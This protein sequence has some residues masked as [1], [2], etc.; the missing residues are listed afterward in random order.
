MAS[1]DYLL[2]FYDMSVK[3]VFYMKSYMETLLMETR[4]C[5][6]FSD[7]EIQDLLMTMG[8]IYRIDYA[9]TLANIFELVLNAALFSVIFAERPMKLEMTRGKYRAIE[10]D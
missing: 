4:F 7:K 2:L 3:G 5:R 10:A 9:K 8:R 1:I 6:L